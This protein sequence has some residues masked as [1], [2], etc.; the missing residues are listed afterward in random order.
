MI[1]DVN[2]IPFPVLTTPR[3]VL[4]QLWE[5]DAKYLALLRSN[6]SVNRYIVRAK[7]TTLKEANAFILV[8]NR[9]ISE[10]KW[11]YWAICQKEHSKLIGT[12]CLWNFSTDHNIAEI[13][14]ELEPAF[15]GKGFMNE[16]VQ[17]VIDFG[18]NKLHLKA[19][20][21]F[22]HKDNTSSMHLLLKNNFQLDPNRKDEE[23]EYNRIYILAKASKE[24]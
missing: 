3:L 4:R 13:G 11:M 16:A 9:G 24:V 19:L 6:E 8:I 22:T 23:N 20:E 1:K 5:S 14:Y 17:C 15:Q 10:K 18:F 7:Q 12:I 2:F 21:A